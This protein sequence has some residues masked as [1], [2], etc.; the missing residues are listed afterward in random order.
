[1]VWTLAAVTGVGLVADA[2]GMECRDSPCFV[3]APDR[4]I[5]VT[6]IVALIPAIIGGCMVVV[7]VRRRRGAKPRA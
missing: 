5:F 2:M 7:W 4:V 3:S 1:V 6:W